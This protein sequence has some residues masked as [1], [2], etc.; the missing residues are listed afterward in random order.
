MCVC[1]SMCVRMCVC[2]CSAAHHSQGF[3]S[4]G[5]FVHI[6]V[7]SSPSVFQAL[8]FHR[9]GFLT[10]QLTTGVDEDTARIRGHTELTRCR[11]VT[12]R[13]QE[14]KSMSDGCKQKLPSF[15]MNETHACLAWDKSL[16]D[17]LCIAVR[18][19]VPLTVC[20][21]QRRCSRLFLSMH[22]TIKWSVCLSTAKPYLVTGSL[23]LWKL[24]DKSFACSLHQRFVQKWGVK[25]T[26]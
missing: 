8:P 13:P 19:Y 10:A 21:Y 23:T 17:R 24:V 2:V 5:F 4:S 14:C 9:P 16:V 7:L 15:W 26:R 12:P 6:C 1:L 18:S 25:A 11:L 20:S 22:H 3:H